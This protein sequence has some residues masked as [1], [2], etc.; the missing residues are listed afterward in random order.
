MS[1]LT[2]LESI[3]LQINNL[4]TDAINEEVEILNVL[5]SQL[6]DFLSAS[7]SA[8]EIDDV[9]KGS[10]DC[11]TGLDEDHYFYADVRNIQDQIINFSLKAK[12]CT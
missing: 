5:H 11:L 8:D 3:K 7:Y 2:T 12:Q 10:G 4:K 6:D 9:L 1:N